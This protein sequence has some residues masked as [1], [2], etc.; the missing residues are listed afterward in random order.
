MIGPN[1]SA[2]IKTRLHWTQ[3]CAVAGQIKQGSWHQAAS[4]PLFRSHHFPSFLRL[5]I[6]QIKPSEIRLNKHPRK[7][8]QY[9][10]QCLAIKTAGFLSVLE[11]A[12]LPVV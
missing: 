8:I 12:L 4:V 1:G 6:N 10:L 5:F 2:S 9:D 7:C 11:G 3:S